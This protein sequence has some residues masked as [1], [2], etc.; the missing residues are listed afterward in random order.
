MG[1][2]I[3]NFLPYVEILHDY[4]Q[5]Y[6]TNLTTAAFEIIKNLKA[7]KELKALENSVV[8]AQRSIQQLQVEKQQTEQELAILNM[9]IMRQQNAISVLS[10]LQ[11]A[12]FNSSQIAELTGLINLWNGIGANTGG[13]NVFGQGNGGG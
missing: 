10:D 2:D 6:N 11:A 12:G 5:R 1:I 13:L 3:T 8:E 4:A 9:S 7:Y